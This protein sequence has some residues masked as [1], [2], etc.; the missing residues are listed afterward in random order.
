MSAPSAAAIVA[1][2]KRARQRRRRRW[3]ITGG[4][5]AGLL[6]FMFF[7]LPPIIRVQ[8]MKR[9]SAELHREVTIEKIRLNPLVL[10]ITIEGLEIKD[11]DGGPFTSWKRLYVNFDSFSVFTG[12]WHFQEIDLEGFSQHVAI[13]KDGTFNF[14]DL[15]PPASAPT[16]APADAPSNPR[17]LR[18]TRL[19]VTSAALAFDDASR[20]TPFSTQVG[21][22]SFELKNFI[23]AGDPKAPYEFAAVTESGETFTWKGTVGID[24]VRSSGSFSLG[25]IALKKYAPY[26]A[27]MVNAD[28]LDGLL[29]VSATYAVEMDAEAKPVRLDLSDAKIALTNLKV[30][31]RDS[32]VALVDL[33]SFTIEGLAADVIKTSA[34]IQ[35][36]ALDGG[37]VS[38]VRESD[39]SINLLNLLPKP[40][41]SG[42]ATVPVAA[43]G[44]AA[45][46]P[47]PDVKL[48]EFAIKGLAIDIEDRTTPSPAKNA[49]KSLDVI[50]KNVSLSE[51]AAPIALQVDV[52]FATGGTVAL[53]G[54]ATR[55]PL[56]ADLGVRVDALSLAGITP[57]VEPFVN[58]RIAGGT[59][60]VDGKA[61]LNGAVAGFTGDV[62]VNKFHTVDGKLGEDFVKFTRFSINGIDAT[63]EPLAAK[64]GSIEIVD[65]LF[66][67]AVYADKSLNLDTILRKDVPS[68]QPATPTVAFTPA[69]VA[70]TPPPVWSL[71]KFTLTNG[72]VMVTDSSVKPSAR[73]ALDQFNGTVTG[74]SSAAPER[75]DLDIHGKFNGTGKIAITGKLDARAITPVAGALTEVTIDVKGLD[76]SP[77]SP[78]IGTYAGYELARS[79]L[80]VDVKTQLTQRKINSENVVVLNQFTLGAP[81]NSPDATKLP[82]RLGVA[83]LKDVDGNIVIDVPVKG[84]LDDPKFKIG[85]VVLNVIVN[86]LVKAATSPFSLIGAAFGG[87][88]DDLAFQQFEAGATLPAA[89]EAAK[90]DTLRK[91]LKGRP[92]LNLDITGSY[93][94]EADLAAVRLKIL[95]KQVRYRLWEE[96]RA[97]NPNTP[98]PAELTVSP[99][100]EARIIG[101]FVAERYPEGLPADVSQVAVLTPATASV[102]V[103]PVKTVRPVRHNTQNVFAGRLRKEEAGPKPVVFA[104]AG[105]AAAT[106][107]GAAAPTMADARQMLAA[108]IPVTDDQ[109]RALA[110]E[111]AQAVRTALLEGGEIAENRLLLTPPATEP[112]GA[113]VLLQL[114]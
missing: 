97:K 76:L 93:D 82:V 13:A 103:T 88:G 2:E 72:K 81:T 12:E 86:L 31:A 45:P 84:S 59:V 110:D 99:E 40:A 75:A 85:K 20:A 78:Y 7:G 22:V 109:L 39:G 11:R 21:P 33:P 57:Y 53:H 69:P 73:L 6:L 36:I 43:T 79:G 9:L 51:G 80:T 4:V 26:Y 48:A 107:D 37:L 27:P 102:P 62:A 52:A 91:A 55:E 8:A 68:A 71:G 94:A 66:R 104:P 89:G 77:I 28:L 58:L 47:L 63:S 35:R 19:K 111:R 95:D 101:L 25:K 18:I 38:A 67:V 56:T 46:A 16:N 64:I 65:P 83:L 3:L 105:G 50:V 113:R 98:P 14:A 74:L 87:G 100:D 90:I 106:G 61:R 17:P 54:S 23:T 15:I 1:Q 92:A 112:K 70:A 32:T 44:A 24:P 5:L 10:S 49:I 114:R 30:A 34:T 60:S 96:L 29:D 41:E 108:A 42:V